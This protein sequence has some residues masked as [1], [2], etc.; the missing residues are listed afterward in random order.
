[1]KIHQ[2]ARHLSILTG[3]IDVIL[4]SLQ[5]SENMANFS[6]ISKTQKAFRFKRFAPIPHDPL[7]RDSA[8]EPR[9]GYAPL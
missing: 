1:M 4:N 5:N 2:N 6:L 8:P 9:W 3:L 7:S